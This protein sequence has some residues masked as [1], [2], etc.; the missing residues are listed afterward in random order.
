[1][2]IFSLDSIFELIDESKSKIK[3]DLDM[4]ELE[5]NKLSLESERL[6]QVLDYSPK[7]LYEQDFIKTLPVIKLKSQKIET[8]SPKK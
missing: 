7:I 8:K 5:H 6:L 4:K 1:M 2:D 3:K